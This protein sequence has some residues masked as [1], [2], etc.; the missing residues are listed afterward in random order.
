MV[1]CERLRDVI[2]THKLYFVLSLTEG[3]MIGVVIGVIAYFSYYPSL[4]V[5]DCNRP[6]AHQTNIHLSDAEVQEPLSRRPLQ[7]V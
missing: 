5:A 6:K 4:S 3:A 2:N 1:W 7:E